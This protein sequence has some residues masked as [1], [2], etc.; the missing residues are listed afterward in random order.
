MIVHEKFLIGGIPKTGNHVLAVMCSKIKDLS[1]E[2]AFQVSNDT[3]RARSTSRYKHDTFTDYNIK[4]KQLVLVIRRLPSFWLSYMWHQSLSTIINEEQSVKK[5]GVGETYEK[6]W[7]QKKGFLF[8]PKIM[9]CSTYPDII[10][11]SYAKGWPDIHWL[12][13]EKLAGDF[14]K[15]IN[16]Y[17]HRKVSVKEYIILKNLSKTDHSYSKSY[18]NVYWNNETLSTLYKYNP[19]WKKLERRIYGAILRL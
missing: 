3:N 17:H 11:K 14:V 18:P 16:K 10:L 2:T 1:V 4:G 19:Y 15:L 13:M 9:C 7:K 5:V 12:R 6:K 8:L